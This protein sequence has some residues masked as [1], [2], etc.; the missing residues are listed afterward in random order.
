MVSKMSRF[1][2]EIT[3]KARCLKAQGAYHPGILARNSLLVSQSDFVKGK[4][5]ATDLREGSILELLLFRSTA[6]Q[7]APNR[8]LC[9]R[10]RGWQW[11]ILKIFLP[12]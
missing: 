11:N 10:R 7:F 2:S 12:A 5:G 6:V 1:R 9:G 3:K 4:R 8:W